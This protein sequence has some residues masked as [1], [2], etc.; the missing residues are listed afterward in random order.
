[1][2]RLNIDEAIFKDLNPRQKAA[3]R[4]KSA[5]AR[6]TR[7][8][9][10]KSQ[11]ERSPREKSSGQSIPLAKM[12]ADRATAACL[13]VEVEMRELK[14]ENDMN[15]LSLVNAELLAIVKTSQD[16]LAV[17]YDG[18]QQMSEEILLLHKQVLTHNFKT[19]AYSNVMRSFGP[20]EY[21]ITL[22][23][24]AL[25]NSDILI[26]KLLNSQDSLL[27]VVRSYEYKNFI[28]QKLV[29]C[30]KFNLQISSSSFSPIDQ[31][32]GSSNT[33]LEGGSKE[34]MNATVNYDNF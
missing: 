23:E 2:Q 26:G 14:Y 9:N 30:L 27:S 33:G 7:G 11:S 20:Q 13:P 22:L 6:F 21:V 25:K 31:E 1:M 18:V 19:C 29:Y 5:G 17:L 8:Q 16:L 4:P 15:E 32:S 10:I 24:E 3:I 34:G 28:T 12:R